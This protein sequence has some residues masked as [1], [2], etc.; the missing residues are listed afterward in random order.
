MIILGIHLYLFS[1]YTKDI[2]ISFNE[3]GFNVKNID[4]IDWNHL[5]TWTL[6]NK[7]KIDYNP[8]SYKINNE[9]REKLPFPLNLF[10]NVYPK[11]GTKT[12]KLELVDK[13]IILFSNVEV[14]DMFIFWNIYVKILKANKKSKLFR[15]LTN[16]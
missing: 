13:R 7:E 2:L 6:V 14:N 11:L 9:I 10:I 1:G 15:K 8:F 12:L 4:F 3:K 16:N 5:K